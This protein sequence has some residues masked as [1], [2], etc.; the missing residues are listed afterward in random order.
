MLSKPNS[1]INKR[2]FGS[3]DKER[4]RKIQSAG[5]IARAKKIKEEKK[6]LERLRKIHGDKI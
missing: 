2:G 1:K 4:A 3:L 6:E 5:G